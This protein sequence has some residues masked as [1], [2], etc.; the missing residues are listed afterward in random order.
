MMAETSTP[1]KPCIIV[2]GGAGNISISR[3]GQVLCAVKEAVKIGNRVLLE[4]RF[5]LSNAVQPGK[6]LNGLNAQQ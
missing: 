4:V 5:T 2:H 6:V 3:R 1:F